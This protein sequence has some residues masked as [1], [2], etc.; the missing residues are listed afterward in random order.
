MPLSLSIWNHILK[1]VSRLR[2]SALLLTIELGIHIRNQPRLHY[3]LSLS[4]TGDEGNR[5][6]A[7]PLPGSLTL[8][9]SAFAPI[10]LKKRGPPS[11]WFFHFTVS[12]SKLKKNKSHQIKP[13]FIPEAL[14][15]LGPRGKR[16]QPTPPLPPP[17]QAIAAG[18]NPLG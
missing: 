16:S 10:L 15:L 2:P 6:P 5:P 11:C 14:P 17:L 3:R 12:L 18:T 7:L 4:V 9:A 8:E 13:G 1:M